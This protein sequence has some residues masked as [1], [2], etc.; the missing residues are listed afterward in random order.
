[1]SFKKTLLVLKELQNVLG[2][3]QTEIRFRLLPVRDLFQLC[4]DNCRTTLKEVFAR[5]FAIMNADTAC[6]PEQALA[7]I[8]LEQLLPK[9]AAFVLTALCRRLGQSDMD[10]QLQAIDLA[11]SRLFRVIDLLEREQPARSRSCCA[12]GVSAGLALAILLI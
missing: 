9:D 12:V 1:M 5:C 4:A 2:L 11:Q 3:M 7:A 6:S 8:D 10:G